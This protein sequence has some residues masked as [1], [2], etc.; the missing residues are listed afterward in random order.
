M[1]RLEGL[2]AIITLA[3]ITGCSSISISTD[4]DSN[5]DFAGYK[6]FGW[7]K[8]SDSGEGYDY[9]GL[10]DERIKSAADKQLQAKGLTKATTD[11]D[12]LVVYHAGKKEQLEVE[13]WGYG[14][15]WGVGGGEAYS[16]EEGT[17][18]VDLVDANTKKM[19]WRGTAK[20]AMSDNPSPE[21]RDAAIDEAIQKMF[22]KYPPSP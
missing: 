4:F 17:L 14:G 12:L 1:R 21:E 13:D 22:E 6:T 3:A 8:Q 18:I 19:V 5:A 16:Y 9:S 2:I 11:T 10:V 7:M 20:K 15:W